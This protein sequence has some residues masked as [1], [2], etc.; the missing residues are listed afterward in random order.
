MSEQQPP[1]LKLCK[2]CKHVDPTG[3][4]AFPEK[5]ACNAPDNLS[6]LISLLD[7]LP[8]RKETAWYLRAVGGLCGP[9]GNWYEY[10]AP[11]LYE[12]FRPVEKFSGTGS[13]KFEI[14]KD[15]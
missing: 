2:D 8:L 15:I 3:C 14:G 11:I 1:K 10:E 13:K 4:H 7:G 5:W 6:A 9:E 12:M